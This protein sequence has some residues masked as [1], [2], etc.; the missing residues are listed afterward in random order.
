MSD[1]A[2]FAVFGDEIHEFGTMSI[3]SAFSQ[4]FREQNGLVLRIYLILR[5][6]R[7]SE[8]RFMSLRQCP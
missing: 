8:T 2:R 5:D 4:R 7:F 1:S 6:S 3:D